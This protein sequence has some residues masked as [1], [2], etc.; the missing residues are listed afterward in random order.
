M[1]DVYF[2]PEETKL[3]GVMISAEGAGAAAVVICHP[4]PQFGGSM[5]NNV[6]LGVEAVLS[7]ADFTTLRFDFRGV[8]RSKGAYDGGVGELDD[9]RRAVDFLAA[10]AAVGKIFVVGYSFGAAVGLKAGAE[11][12]RVAALVGIAPP[13]ALDPCEFLGNVEKPMLLVAGSQD[14]FCDAATLKGYLKEQG[15]RLEIVPGAD[16]F[17]IGSETRL[18]ELAC[19]FLKSL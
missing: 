9:V 6:V 4:H 16:H 19:E 17:F 10:D 5:N 13:T 15:A 3:N 1:R 14:R 18:G 7:D 12:S 2:G 11:D 8:G